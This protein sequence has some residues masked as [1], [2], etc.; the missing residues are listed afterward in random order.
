MPPFL[1]G[2]GTP[3]LRVRHRSIQMY[4]LTC[5]LTWWWLKGLD[6]RATRADSVRIVS[7]RSHWNLCVGTFPVTF[8]HR[9]SYTW[10]MRIQQVLEPEQTPRTRKGSPKFR[11][12]QTLRRSHLQ[13][14]A[15]RAVS[16]LSGDGSISSNRRNI[17]EEAGRQRN[18]IN[19]ARLTRRCCATRLQ[20]CFGP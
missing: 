2:R 9:R 10:A 15:Q 17:T 12:G 20:N 11:G 1:H 4:G 3:W 14:A 5:V 6:R 16:R 18:E 19:H 7:C 13:N 8:L